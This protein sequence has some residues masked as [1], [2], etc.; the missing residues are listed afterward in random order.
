MSAAILKTTLVLAYGPFLLMALLYLAG[1]LL[2]VSGRPHF[3][4]LL[5]ARTSVPQPIVRAHQ[6]TDA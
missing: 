6:D 2:K 3:L 5:I 1:L 4:S